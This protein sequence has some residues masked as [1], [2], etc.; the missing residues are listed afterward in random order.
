MGLNNMGNIYSYVG[1]SRIRGLMY[2]S[3]VCYVSFPCH[4]IWLRIPSYYRPQFDQ[5]FDS[6]D[7]GTFRALRPIFRL[8]WFG[9]SSPWRYSKKSAAWAWLVSPLNPDE[10]DPIVS[11]GAAIVK[12][13]KY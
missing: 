13:R 3:M 9:R 5:C 7:W 1:Y 8:Y 11:M 6:S 10:N 4:M 12:V 2:R